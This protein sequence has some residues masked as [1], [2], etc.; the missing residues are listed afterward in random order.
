[1]ALAA[2]YEEQTEGVGYRKADAGLS[3]YSDDSI[4][5]LW[6]FLACTHPRLGKF[7]PAAAL[8]R[9]PGLLGNIAEGILEPRCFVLTASLGDVLVWSESGQ[10][11]LRLHHG[12]EVMA[13]QLCFDPDV[14]VSIAKDGSVKQWAVYGQG[15]MLS[16]LQCMCPV[17]SAAVSG[18]LVLLG[19][20]AGACHLYSL[21]RGELLRT[22]QHGSPVSSVAL[23]ARSHKMLTAPWAALRVDFARE[24]VVFA[25]DAKACSES[26]GGD[27]RDVIVFNHDACVVALDVDF[28][29]GYVFT[30]T[31]RGTC[32][33]WS[34]TGGLLHTCCRHVDAITSV[35]VNASR[36]CLLTGSCDGTAKLWRLD[37][38]L[39]ATF[40]HDGPVACAGLRC[41]TSDAHPVH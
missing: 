27:E 31:S 35:A 33:L 2:P 20:D 37:G 4:S 29:H 1:M 13:T 6:A 30:G 40:Q 26:T 18:D 19:T 25:S 41:A 3:P 24:L 7:S 34:S 16:C 9:E 12:G 38:R 14:V 15:E 32:T 8:S 10:L 11:L 21:R 17:L 5:Q 28:T 22:I 39:I 36:D 23:E